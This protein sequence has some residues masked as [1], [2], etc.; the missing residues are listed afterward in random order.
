MSF[1]SL[2]HYQ[3]PQER[4]RDK[5][6]VCTLS[7]YNQHSVYR[8]YELLESIE[9]HWKATVSIRPSVRPSYNI[10]TAQTGGP[11]FAKLDK[12]IAPLKVTLRLY[13][14]KY[15]SFLKLEA[16]ASSP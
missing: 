13:I 11:Q 5:F 4:T 7:L 8:R 14:L 1:I 2:Y 3:R 12:P 9:F 15:I 6:H 10:N 16:T